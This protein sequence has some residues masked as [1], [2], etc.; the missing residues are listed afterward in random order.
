MGVL[1][2]IKGFVSRRLRDGRPC[3]EWY[4]YEQRERYNGTLWCHRKRCM[5][6]PCLQLHLC[7]AGTLQGL[8]S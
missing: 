7:V 6:T 5:H 4:A 3:A 8:R 2:H 1:G